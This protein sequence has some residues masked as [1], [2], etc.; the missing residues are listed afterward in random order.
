MIAVATVPLGV[1][2][3]YQSGGRSDFRIGSLSNAQGEP[4]SA[5]QGS[6]AIR[7]RQQAVVKSKRAVRR[8]FIAIALCSGLLRPS[9]S[10]KQG[11]HLAHK[12]QPMAAS[13]PNEAGRGLD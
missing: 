4:V 2:K 3:R 11:F 5:E 1:P 9:S 13:V 10:W 8:N 7:I 12:N 6:I